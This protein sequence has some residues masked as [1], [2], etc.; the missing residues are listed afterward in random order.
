M[1]VDFAAIEAAAD[2]IRD[3]VVRTPSAYSRTLSAITGAE[4]WLKFENLQFTASFKDRGALNR[5]LTLTP[6]QRSRGVIALSAGN[7]AQGVA[8]HAE[9]LGIPATI[10]MPFFTPFAKVRQTRAFGARVLLE[11]ETLAECQGLVDRLGEKEGLTLIHPYDDEKIIAGQ[12]TCA[13]EF[14]SDHKDIDI[15]AL[16]IGG[17]GFIAGSAIAAKALKPDIEVVGVEASLYPS[18]YQ[19]LHALKP[20]AAGQTIAE[21]IAV[22]YPGKLTL[23]VV[24]DLVSEILLVDESDIEHAMALFIEIEKTV[25]EGAGATGLAALLAYPDR[26]A[27]RKVGLVVTGGNVDSRLLASVLM[28]EQVRQGRVVRLRIKIPDTP[29]TLARITGLL[30]NAGGNVID[31]YHNRLFSDV[32]AK[33][34]NLDLVIETRDRQH[35]RDIIQAIESASFIVSVLDNQ[36]A[37][38]EE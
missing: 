8:Y 10:V 26:F 27:G 12:G 37:S 14:V 30:A 32:S 19:A 7:H 3:A 1:T 9:R 24:R 18:M 5:M 20:S 17:G 6:E 2:A 21:G 22:K 31:V 4:V 36:Q 35:M 28:R 23:P 11:G 15:L 33:H 13:L 34:A 16:P 25:S 29:G 38:G